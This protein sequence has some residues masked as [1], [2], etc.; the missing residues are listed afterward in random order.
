MR[1][2]IAQARL[3]VQRQS[4]QLKFDRNQLLPQLDAFGN[5]GYNGTGKEF[6]DALY[7]VQGLNRPFY[8]FGGRL[9]MPLLNLSAKN[10]YRSDKANMQQLELTLKRLE[11]GTLIQ[12]DDD[13]ATIRANYDQVL[14][15]REARR[16]QEAA[17]DALRRERIPPSKSFAFNLKSRYLKKQ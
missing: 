11:Q 10:T 14:A 9:N 13:I 12:I 5:Y 16:Y 2:E 15:T 6:S 17:L 1:Q 7:D 3:D 4:L 8:T